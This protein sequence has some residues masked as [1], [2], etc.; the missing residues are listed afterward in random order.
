MILN[1]IRRETG[2]RYVLIEVFQ[3]PSLL[4][5]WNHYMLIYIYKYMTEDDQLNQEKFCKSGF[6]DVM[7]WFLIDIMKEIH[8]KRPIL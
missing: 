6:L 8:D 5:T 2:P 3:L 7:M 1:R 4:T